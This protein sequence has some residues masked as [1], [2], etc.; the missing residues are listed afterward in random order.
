MSEQTLTL[1]DTKDRV[2]WTIE[3]LD[4]KLVFSAETVSE[5]IIKLGEARAQM[6]PAVERDYKLGQ[7]VA[8]IPDPIWA[9]EPDLM[10]GLSLLH[11]RDQRFGW[12]HYAFPPNEAAKLGNYLLKQAEGA[13]ERLKP[14]S[15]H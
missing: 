7:V 5:L 8:T 1:N 12:L 4:L 14:H 6:T 2:T 10:Q 15:Q 9:T 13:A 3:D 11:I